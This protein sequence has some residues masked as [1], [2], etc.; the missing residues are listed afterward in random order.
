MSGVTRERR[1]GQ[2]VGRT[3]VP[4]PRPHGRPASPARFL[5]RFWLY[6]LAMGVAGALLTTFVTR[7][8]NQSDSL[9]ALEA[10]RADLQEQLT[11]MQAEGEELRQ[12]LTLLNDDKYIEQVARQY[13]YIKDGEVRL[14]PK[15][16]TSKQ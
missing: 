10:Q 8:V 4:R 5:R 1:V 6:L 3:A 9:A 12:R 15:P 13:G 16:A 2:T 7:V 11:Q 14:M